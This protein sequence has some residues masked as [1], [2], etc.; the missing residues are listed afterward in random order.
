MN[1]IAIAS[2]FSTKGS[3]AVSVRVPKDMVNMLLIATSEQYHIKL[4]KQCLLE[5]IS[6]RIVTGV[7]GQR[8]L[9]CDIKQRTNHDTCFVVQNIRVALHG[10]GREKLP[11]NSTVL[12]PGRI[13]DGV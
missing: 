1:S 7:N 13:N 2:A 6:P 9:F 8:S 11:S 4:R 3:V 10:L 12:S 5:G